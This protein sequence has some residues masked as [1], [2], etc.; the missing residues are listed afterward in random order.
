M[1]LQRRREVKMIKEANIVISAP[2]GVN[3]GLY[4]DYGYVWRLKEVLYQGKSLVIYSPS[5][6]PFTTNDFLGK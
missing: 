1:Y 3:M 5:I 2:G 6:G 4:R